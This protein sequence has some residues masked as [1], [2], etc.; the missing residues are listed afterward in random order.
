MDDKEKIKRSVDLRLRVQK[1]LLGSITPNMRAIFCEWI[2]NAI[3]VHLIF[4]GE[5]HEQDIEE[6]KLI[7]LKVQSLFPGNEIEVYT[8]RFDL[9]QNRPDMGD[10]FM[11][12]CRKE[13]KV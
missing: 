13:A 7:K 12:Y 9:P 4:D 10:S 6:V 1:A 2:L 3:K 8:S 5:I 11:V